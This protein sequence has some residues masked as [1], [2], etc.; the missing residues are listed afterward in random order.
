[1]INF[2]I[3]N[4][5]YVRIQIIIKIAFQIL[6]VLYIYN[7]IKFSSADQYFS[8]VTVKICNC[9]C[10]FGY[11]EDRLKTEQEELLEYYQLKTYY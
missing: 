7:L 8:K 5:G 4:K 9:N 2:S 6:K 10:I 1:M 3:S 11:F